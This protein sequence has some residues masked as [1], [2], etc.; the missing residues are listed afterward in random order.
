MLIAKSIAKE[1]EG[2]TFLTCLFYKQVGTISSQDDS[3]KNNV[4]SQTLFFSPTIQ[5][6]KIKILKFPAEL[7]P[8]KLVEWQQG[9]A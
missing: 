6:S 2:N 9:K 5:N 4:W 7:H 1:V 8:S 3:L